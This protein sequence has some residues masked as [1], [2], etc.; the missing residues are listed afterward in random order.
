MSDF[1]TYLTLSVRASV[2]FWEYT[3]NKQGGIQ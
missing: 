2:L 1:K 3:S